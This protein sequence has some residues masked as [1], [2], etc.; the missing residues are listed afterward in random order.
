[1]RQ[2]IRKTLENTGILTAGAGA[3]AGG[4]ALATVVVA[5]K[6]TGWWI[7]KKTIDITLAEYVAATLG[8]STAAASVAIPLF[9][10]AGTIYAT[11]K[12]LKHYNKREGK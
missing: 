11:S 8:I 5:T 7:F 1:M 3:A 12:I 6:T 9:C 4:N 2:V 10:T